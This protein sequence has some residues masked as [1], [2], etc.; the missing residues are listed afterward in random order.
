MADLP[1][2]ISDVSDPSVV[3]VKM[4][5]SGREV[6]APLSAVGV[7]LKAYFDTLYQPLAAR[8]TSWAAVVR[9]AGFDTFA[10]TPTSANLRALLTD[11]TGTG[12]AVFAGAPT[13]TGIPVFSGIPSLTGGALSFPA[14]QVPS[15]GPNDLDDYEEGT[16]TPTL[17][18]AG[19]TF[20]Y[21]FRSGKYTKIGRVVFFEIAIGLNTS[22]NTLTA[23]SITITGMP[24]T[25]AS[26]QTEFPVRWVAS[27]T[28]YIT[29]FATTINATTTLQ[30]EGQT[31]AAIN[32][33]FPLA[34]GLL[35]ATNGTS[36]TVAGY[37]HV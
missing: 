8:L 29:V 11:E 26:S 12:A 15:A 21:A 34:N 18:A 19:S 23:S 13:I 32:P 31:A 22:G 37:H 20:S 30:I 36:L 10:A 2:A 9:A 35:H 16:F 6:H 7:A 24:F 27:T 14:T 5:A 33:G 28:S 25:L 17:L 4:L 1:V 3:R